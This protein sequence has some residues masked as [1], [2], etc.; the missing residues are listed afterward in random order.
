MIFKKRK[1]LMNSLRVLYQNEDLSKLL[2]KSEYDIITVISYCDLGLEKDGFKCKRKGLA[3]IHLYGSPEEI[4]G[5]FVRTTRQEVNQTYDIEGLLFRVGE[6]N[7]KEMYELYSKFELAQERKPWGENTFLGVINF[8]A[9]YNGELIASVPCYDLY[10]YL[11][12]RAIFSKRLDVSNQTLRKIIGR[13]GRRLI[14]EI[15]KYGKERE[16]E[17]VSLG[18]VNYSTEQKSNVADFKMFF[19]PKIGDE[20]TYTY[21]SKKFLFLEK[22][23]KL[24]TR[25]IGSSF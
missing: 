4:L 20:F 5:R 24:I 8:N 7:S 11:Q 1:F 21:K 3:N 25:K 19:G 9:Y 18:S 15:C 23:K 14:F 16:Y 2:D 17:F 6:P 22:V 10:P 13:A 12:V